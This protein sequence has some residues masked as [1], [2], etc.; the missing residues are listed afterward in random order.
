MAKIGAFI[1]LASNDAEATNRVQWLADAMSL[2]PNDFATAFGG[3]DFTNYDNK[4]SQLATANPPSTV[5][6]FITSCWPTTMSMQSYANGAQQ[7]VVFAGLMDSVS[8]RGSYNANVTGIRSF[9][10]NSLCPNWTYLLLQMAP[11]ITQVAILYDQTQGHDVMGEQRDAIKSV[12]AP[13]LPRQ[14]SF[15]EID[16]R[17]PLGTI[18]QKLKDFAAAAP[19]TSG[20]IVTAGT[21]DSMNRYNFADRI[22]GFAAKHNIPAI[23]A[24]GMYVDAGGGLM[25]YGPNLQSL[26]KKAAMNFALKIYDHTIP[27]AQIPNQLQ[28]ETYNDISKFE[29]RIDKMTYNQL[30]QK[31]NNLAPLQNTY[32]VRVP[33]TLGGPD[34]PIQ[35]S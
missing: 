25:S 35:P 3:G 28:I 32:N 26:Y 16:A 2:T 9:Y 6:C 14:L 17:A 20:L 12:T 31:L 23:Y 30:Q 11:A 1:N 34:Q 4:A 18:D 29:L 33:W 8:Q 27:I 7:A 24:N 10:P 21:L 13:P 5:N 15:T 19:T 22:A